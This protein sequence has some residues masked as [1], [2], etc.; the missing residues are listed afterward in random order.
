M[1]IESRVL[2]QVSKVTGEDKRPD[3]V[4]SESIKEL[5]GKQFD[6]KL[7]I[8]RLKAKKLQ[9]ALDALNERINEREKNKG[10]VIDRRFD[11]LLDPAKTW[12]W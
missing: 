3:A 11:S 4:Q 10:V 6:A 8:Q 9:K 12:S 7:K 2:D 1:G 5:I